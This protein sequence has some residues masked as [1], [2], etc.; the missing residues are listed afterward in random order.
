MPDDLNALTKYTLD[1][2]LRVHTTLGPGLLESA[3]TA[4]LVYELRKLGL[5]I[6]TEVP[7]PL[8]YDGVQLAD[9]GFIID[10]LVGKELVV[11]VRSLDKID[12]EHRAQLI[13]CLK[14]SRHRVGLLL[15]F[16]AER[17]KDGIFRHINTT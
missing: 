7:V 15:N 2:A 8:I 5:E 13:S 12:R 10:I 14:L 17:F 9:A 11:A 1:A 3:Y 16:N 6:A 4:C